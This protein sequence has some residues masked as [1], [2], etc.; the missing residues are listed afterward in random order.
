MPDS[1]TISSAPHPSIHHFLNA[2]DTTALQKYFSLT[3]LV[4]NLYLITSFFQALI[5]GNILAVPDPYDPTALLHLLT[6]PEL[7]VL[8]NT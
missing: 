8:S 3:Y 4:N 5:K 6:S 1:T 7:M 2:R